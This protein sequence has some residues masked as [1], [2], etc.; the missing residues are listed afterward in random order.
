MNILIL[1]VFFLFFSSMLGMRSGKCEKHPNFFI[2]PSESALKLVEQARSNKRSCSPEVS[3]IRSLLLGNKFPNLN[4]ST[5]RFLI[6]TDKEVLFEVLF[7]LLNNS[8]PNY[9]IS[10]L[11][12]YSAL[13]NSVKLLQFLYTRGAN[14]NC[15]NNKDSNLLSSAAI[16]NNFEVIKY[17]L[18]SRSGFAVDLKSLDDS[19]ELCG[20]CCRRRSRA[21]LILLYAARAGNRSG[22]VIV[23]DLNLKSRM[24]VI[25]H[26]ST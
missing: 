15:A 26:Y 21:C 7:I 16:F 20:Q 10:L 8:S 18:D 22:R 17:L 9:L 13:F 11:L 3:F 24:L 23:E 6:K 4:E 14:I 19:I 25:C 12:E 5:A 2:T 1:I